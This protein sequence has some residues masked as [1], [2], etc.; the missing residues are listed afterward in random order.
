M[1]QPEKFYNDG[2]GWKCIKCESELQKQKGRS[3]EEISRLMKEGEA[4][5][6]TPEF[7][8]LALAKWVDMQQKSLIC[9]RCGIFE[10]IDKR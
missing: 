6:K 1:S 4:E 9:P 3:F 5:S 7:S 8:N 2:F 10:S